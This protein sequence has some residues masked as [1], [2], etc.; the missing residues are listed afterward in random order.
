M[1]DDRI[2]DDCYIVM[3]KYGI[4]RMTKRPGKLGRG[5]VAVRV[6]LTIP[7]KVFEEP[8]F[9]AIV[10]VP[11]SAVLRPDATVEVV[12]PEGGQSDE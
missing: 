10:T 12:E 8:I 11:E 1:S 3:S 9:S 2:Y 7:E 6:R 4:Q 5:E